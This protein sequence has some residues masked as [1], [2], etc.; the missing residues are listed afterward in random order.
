MISLAL[1]AI[2]LAGH[3]VTVT[4]AGTGVITGSAFAGQ[5]HI[6]LSEPACKLARNG[7]GVGVWALLH[8]LGHTLQAVPDEHDAD[9]YAQHHLRGA[10]RRFWHLRPAR[11]R[12]EERAA[13]AFEDEAAA[14][15][16]LY[17]CPA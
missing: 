7:A 4:C 11:L 3:P 1:V 10:L 14:I 8:E 16:P 5:P 15:N 6:W 12:R 2:A 13:L 17:G 9:C